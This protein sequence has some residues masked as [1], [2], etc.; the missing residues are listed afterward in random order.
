MS[1][2]RWCVFV[3]NIA[4]LRISLVLVVLCLVQGQHQAVVAQSAAP[5]NVAPCR[6]TITQDIDII[7]GKDTYADVEPGDT[8]CIPAGTRG[9]L[10]IRNLRGKAGAPIT[11]RND[12]GQVRIQG[13]KFRHGITL[14][15][16]AYLRLTGTGVR[17][18]CGAPYA[19]DQ[20]QC[21]F[22]I[23]GFA[24]AVEAVNNSTNLEYD[25][26]EG[27]QSSEAAFKIK[28]AGKSIARQYVHHLY[29]H[30]TSEE[31]LYMGEAGNDQSLDIVRG[32]EVSYNLVE[33]SGWDAI[34]VKHT[35]NEVQVHHNVI[36][37][38]GLLGVTN[39]DQGLSIGA[40]GSGD[41]YNNLIVKAF[42]P[43]LNIR[44]LPAG[45]KIY[46]NVIVDSGGAGIY[47]NAGNDTNFYNNT[48]INNQQGGI[49]GTLRARGAAFDNVIVGSPSAI[50]GP[51]I[52]DDNNFVGTIA[53]AKFVDAAGG[54]YRLQ[55]DSPLIDAGRSSGLFP[56][57]DRQDVL[58]PQGTTTDLGAYE[59]EG[60][61]A[62]PAAARSVWPTLPPLVLVVLFVITSMLVFV[63]RGHSPRSPRPF[64]VRTK[65]SPNHWRKHR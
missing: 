56:A 53:D 51:G 24:K 42:G 43:G 19:A 39:Q 18:Q 35:A 31:G 46:N 14:E 64:G 48:L 30:D 54:D 57:N 8:V 26:L 36:R 49:V 28:G 17:E 44:T 33:R 61:P 41:Y 23:S 59:F 34:N 47:Y 29:A 40:G 5:Q 60:D 52:T 11:I 62:P 12:G 2:Y 37:E 4:Q 13:G 27:T 22:V 3:T 1:A 7:D 32:L 38:S 15:N 63:W 58:R 45:S 16:N 10:Q 25:H 20:Q 21:G 50:E 65:L 55:S 6:V 9:S